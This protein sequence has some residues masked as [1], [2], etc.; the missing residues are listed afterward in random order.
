M[1]FKLVQENKQGSAM[2]GMVSTVP[3]LSVTTVELALSIHSTGETR[4]NLPFLGLSEVVHVPD[5][6]LLNA[7]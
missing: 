2:S 3:S 4:P 5:C 7:T 1:P 6:G